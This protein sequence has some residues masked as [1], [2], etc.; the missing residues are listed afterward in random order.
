MEIE[1][2]SDDSN[3]YIHRGRDN[4]IYRYH[5]SWEYIKV[6]LEVLGVLLPKLGITVKFYNEY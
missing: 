5:H 1:I 6:I 2:W 4:E 3:I